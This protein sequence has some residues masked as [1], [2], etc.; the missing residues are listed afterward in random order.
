MSN[1]MLSLA[2]SD[3]VGWGGGWGGPWWVVFPLLWI[4]LIATVV[5]LVARNRRRDSTMERPM[6][7]LAAR[8]ARGEVDT[9]EY[10]RRL[11]EI[12]G[13]S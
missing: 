4:A 8:Y 2:Q 11:D 12:R 3:H 9:D 7:I 1:L 13:Q 5:W 6:E 10:R